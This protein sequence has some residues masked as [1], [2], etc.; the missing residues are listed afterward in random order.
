MLRERV[1]IY[2]VLDSQ[3]LCVY[4]SIC[5]IAVEPSSSEKEM[6]MK[7]AKP[8]KSHAYQNSTRYIGSRTHKY[9]HV[10]LQ[11]M[12]YLYINATK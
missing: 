11:S 12:V 2:W 3:C 5:E 1:E 9:G 7:P 10:R 6:I 8:E 4:L